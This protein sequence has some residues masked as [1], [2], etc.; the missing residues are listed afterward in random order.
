M[1][2]PP[3]NLLLPRSARALPTRTRLRTRPVPVILY[4]VGLLLLPV[5]VVGAGVG[6]GWWA[7][8]GATAVR[9]A[10]GAQPGAD[11]GTAPAAPVDPADV[12]GSMTVQQV[13]DAFPPVTAAEVL[14]R[15]GAPAGTPASTPLKTLVEAG[16]GTDI[17]AIR[18]WLAERTTG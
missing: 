12:K 17:P 2:R 18:T 5:L 14:A 1:K 6:A 4:V 13:V 10:D 15:F 11:G 16:D 3:E 7:T 8:T 9:Q